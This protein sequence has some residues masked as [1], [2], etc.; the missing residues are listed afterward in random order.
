[1]IGIVYGY[2][3]KHGGVGR[4]ISEYLRNIEDKKNFEIISTEIDIHLPKQIRTLLINCERDRRFMSID[5]NKSF[6]QSIRRLT[7]QYEII[8][9]HGIYDFLPNFYTAHICINSYFNKF[10]DIFGKSALPKHLRN[11][12]PILID[13]EDKIL[14]NLDKERLIFV[15]KKVA[16]ELSTR[17]WLSKDNIKIIHGASRF[18][19]FTNKAKRNLDK[20]YEKKTCTIGFVGGDLYAKG[21]VF[22]KDALNKLA[23]K[24]F[25]IRCIGVCWD[26]YVGE[27]LK[28]GSRYETE[29]FG[30]Y[31][32]N[33]D[34]YNKLDVFLNLSIYEAYSLTTLEAM[35]LGIPVVSSNLNGVF[36]DAEQEDLTLAKVKDVSNHMEVASVLEKILCDE[37]FKKKVVE[38]GY[39]LTRKHTWKDVALEYERI[40]QKNL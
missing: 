3:V 5:E 19:Q 37:S 10:I 33:E 28:K 12:Y 32:I 21:I 29:L 22:L 27:F 11:S 6:S 24:G 17:Y 31:E 15:S 30:R 39:K 23:S 34:F 26:N 38:S 7:K 8:H 2:C 9:S 18:H 35:S 1:M 16:D 4:Y 40:Y 25:K 20:K 36:Y 14:S 13:F